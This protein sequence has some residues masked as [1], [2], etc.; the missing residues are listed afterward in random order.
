M[1]VILQD[2][3]IGA[4]LDPHGF[5]PPAAGRATQSTARKL[6]GLLRDIETNQLSEVR[7]TRIR[8]ADRSGLHRTPAERVFES[9]MSLVE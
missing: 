5:R 8:G 6:L 4:W 3:R 9:G 7:R 1:P 2:D